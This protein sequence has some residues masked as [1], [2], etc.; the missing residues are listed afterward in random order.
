MP[1]T[2][3]SNIKLAFARSF[4][5]VKLEITEIGK[6]STR[7]HECGVEEEMSQ[8]ALE[9]VWSGVGAS[10]LVLHQHHWDG[11][12]ADS[13]SQD[14][15]SQRDILWGGGLLLRAY[16]ASERSRKVGPLTGPNRWR[17]PGRRWRLHGF[18]QP[19]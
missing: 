5:C 7:C 9:Q 13:R 16:H 3:R 19:P 10:A 12:G 1:R 6:L 11:P 14:Y 18:M 8:H 2:V 4:A 17:R 15:S